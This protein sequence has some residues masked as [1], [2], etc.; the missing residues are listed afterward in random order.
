MFTVFRISGPFT[1]KPLPFPLCTQRNFCISNNHEKHQQ[2]VLSRG[3]VCVTCTGKSEELRINPLLWR[4]LT[5][6][7]AVGFNVPLGKA[8]LCQILV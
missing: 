6:I 5:Q 1:L 7:V 4:E 8:V 2:N 3:R